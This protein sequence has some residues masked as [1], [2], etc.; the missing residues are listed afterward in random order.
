MADEPTG[1]L[2][3]ETAAGIFELFDRLHREHG[4][5]IVLVTHDAKL[6]ACT[7]RTVQMQDGRI[8]SDGR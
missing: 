7:Q 4:M 1:N 8:V 6:A 5:T 3:S 2:D